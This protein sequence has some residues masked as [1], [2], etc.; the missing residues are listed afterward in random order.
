MKTLLPKYSN[1]LL[2]LST[3]KELQEFIAA[4]RLLELG[5]QLDLDTKLNQAYKDR[6]TERY[7]YF[8]N[9]DFTELQRLSRLSLDRKYT[10][11]VNDIQSGHLTDCSCDLQSILTDCIYITYLS[12]II[13][14]LMVADF[15]S[16]YLVGNME[17]LSV[18]D[19][20][21]VK[22]YGTVDRISYVGRLIDFV[23]AEI[24]QTKEDS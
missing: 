11:I 22:F 15:Q 5:F 2:I 3:K 23:K 16:G 10:S 7:L 21:S 12:I 24:G 1:E 17:I 20:S 8:F 13:D 6:E 19:L 18:V 9:K 14:K 4:A